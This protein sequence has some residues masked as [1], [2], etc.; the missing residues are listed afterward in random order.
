MTTLNDLATEIHG[1]SKSKGFW[2]EDA[3]RNPG[4]VLMLIVSEA[5]EAMEAI[6]DGH[7]LG[8]PAISWMGPPE[9][10]FPYE[11]EMSSAG[12]WAKRGDDY[13]FE[14]TD[15]AYE[16]HGFMGKPVGVPS[17]MADILIRVLDACAAW[18]I[19]V[20]AAVRSKI[21]YNA[22]RDRLHGRAR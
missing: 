11:I 3:T 8:K 2:P 1:I 4:E 6:R 18:G 20:D 10:P 13:M 7:D 19:D 21:I 17:E 16:R 12:T 22:T 15:E 14:M 9:I 5:A